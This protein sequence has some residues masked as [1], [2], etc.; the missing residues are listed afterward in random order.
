MLKLKILSHFLAQ[1]VWNLNVFL[2]ERF[3]KPADR[4]ENLSQAVMK[5]SLQIHPW[6]QKSSQ[7]VSEMLCLNRFEAL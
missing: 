7:H 1:I 2:L 3:P 6:P 4:K 5:R